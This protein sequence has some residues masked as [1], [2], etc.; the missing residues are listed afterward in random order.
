LR[1][2]YHP[3]RTEQ[4]P[5][6]IPLSNWGN[7][8]KVPTRLY[9]FA[10]VEEARALLSQVNQAIPRGS[11]R[12]YGDSALAE[13]I[14]STLRYN[15]FLA[16]DPKNGLPVWLEKPAFQSQRW[17]DHSQARV[18]SDPDDGRYESAG[19]IDG[20]AAAGGQSDFLRRISRTGTTSM[21]CRSGDTLCRSFGPCLSLSSKG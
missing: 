13:N 11:G 14:I 5:D 21:F 19:T 18:C 10:E 16:F 1:T 4:R 20:H 9:T 15:K 8:P 6:L 3:Y 12:C 2:D 17:G 7:Y